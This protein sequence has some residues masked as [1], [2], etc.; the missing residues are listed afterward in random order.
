MGERSTYLGFIH[1]SQSRVNQSNTKYANPG[2]DFLSV[3]R[4]RP[5]DVSG[6]SN[7]M[8][9]FVSHEGLPWCTPTSDS[10]EP[11]QAVPSSF[12]HYQSCL[13]RP[14]KPSADT[15]FRP[16]KTVGQ[17]RERNQTTKSERG[18]SAALLLSRS[19]RRMDRCTQRTQC[20]PT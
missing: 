5:C 8:T 15:P 14:V 6:K 7:T 9:V 4:R 17:T 3:S 13:T 16:K 20:T 11:Y 1:S 2:S 18:P 19:R 10:F 12:D